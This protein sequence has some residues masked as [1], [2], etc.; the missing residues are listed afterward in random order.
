MVEFG[1]LTVL[2]SSSCIICIHK[3]SIINVKAFSA[4]GAGISSCPTE[5]VATP[6]P[7]TE[8]GPPK[9]DPA[10]GTP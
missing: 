7:S 6:A 1:K 10:V 2:V 4:I 5:T 9:T 3:A 8:A